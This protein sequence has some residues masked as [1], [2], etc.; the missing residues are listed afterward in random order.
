VDG[1]LNDFFLSISNFYTE[2]DDDL[3]DYN[4]ERLSKFKGIGEINF[5]D[6]QKLV[7]VT[8][9]ITRDLTERSGKKAQYEIAKK[10]LKKYMR[11]DAGIFVF[12]DSSGNFRLSLVYGTPDTTRMVWSNFR[13]FTYFISQDEPH[14]TFD[15][16]IGQCD[17]SSLGTI[18][19]AFS[20]ERVTK[21]FY[22][23]YDRKF[24]NS[25]SLIQG[26]GSSD[27]EKER[28]RLFTQ[29]LF[30]RLMFIA[31]IEKKGWLKFGS[32]IDYLYALW[33][34]YKKSSNSNT[35]FYQERLKLLFFAGLNTPN[36]IRK[37]GSLNKIIGDVQ[38]L[39]GGL[40]EE[41][42]DDRDSNI[43]VLDECLGNIIEDL[44]KRFNFTVTENTPI[45]VEVAVDPEML[46]KVFEEL[47]TGRHETGS[48]YTPK[49]VVSF[50]CREAI[51]AYLG[52]FEK[53]V[54]NQDIS[55]VSVADARNLIS[56][57]K[58]ITV[59]DPACGSGAYLVG[60]L[61]ELQTLHRILDTRA[62]EMTARDDYQL[63]LEI[64][65]NNLYG[66]DLDSFAVNIARLRLW[67]TLAVEYDGNKPEPLPNLDFKIEIGD[68]LTAPDP[69]QGSQQ[70]IVGE[71]AKR[72]DEKTNVFMRTHNYGLKAPLKKEIEEIEQ[73]IA[74]WMHA[75]AA[76]SG[77]DWAV[78]FAGVFV[79]GGFD[80]ILANPPYGI[81]C[82]DPL[83]F[84]YFPRVK[85]ED[86]QSKDSYGLFIARGLQMLKSGGILTYIVSDTWRTIRTHYPLRKKLINETQLMHVLDLP[87]WIFDATVN[88][89][90]FTTVKQ[91]PAE[92][93]VLIAGDLRN[94]PRGDWTALEQNLVTISA[95]GPDCS[96]STYARYTYPQNLIPTYD[97]LS[98]FIGSPNLYRLMSAKRFVRLNT[99]ADVK[100]G[101]ATADNQYY[102]R[103]R[104]DSRGSY[105]ILDQSHLMSEKDLANLSDSEK[106]NGVNPA[107][108]RNRHFVPYDKGGPSDADGG[109][110]PNY[111]VPTDYF[112]DWSQTA[113]TRLK[114]KT[115]E[116]QGGRLASR[117]QNF[118][119]YFKEGISFSDTGF[120][121]PT[122]RV[123]CCGV[124]DVMGM[125]VFTDE[126]NTKY[127]L[128][129]LASRLIRYVI[130]NY[131]NHSI[132]TQVEGL[133]PIPILIDNSAFQSRMIR[134]VDEIIT[135]QREDARYPY[136]LYEQ[137]EIDALVYQLYGLTDE[138]I[139]EVELWYCRRYPKLAEAQG[140]F[141]EVK[142]KYSEHL[143]RCDLVMTKGP[144]YWKS[145]PVLS[146]I[147][148][149]E[150]ETLEFKET[151]DAD[152]K[153][154][155]KNAGVLLSSLKTIAAFLNTDGGTMMIGVSDSG[156]I[157][158]L[159]KDYKL[160]NKHDKD[161][162]EQK[163][164]SLVT[165]RF[166]PEPKGK[167]NVSF[168][169]VEDRQ[170]CV[171]IVETSED[172][173]HLDGKD[174][175]IRE[176]NTSRKL[177]G[178]ALVNFVQNRSKKEQL[179]AYEL[180]DLT[181]EE[182]A[183]VEGNA[184]KA[185]K[186]NIT[187]AAEISPIEGVEPDDQEENIEEAA[188]VEIILMKDKETPGTWRYKEQ[189][190]DH[191]LTIYLTKEQVKEL[192][193]P[194]S[195]KITVT[196]A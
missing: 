84:Q 111:Y 8:A 3:V 47:V 33:N 5:E 146:L 124:F 172:I 102:L 175:Y 154:G 53:L 43:K 7:V 97:N 4:D 119:C 99:I 140:V 57:L 49:T 72:V 46:G 69:H 168:E 26:F 181:P 56:K 165:S 171:A 143:K 161:G 173:S 103:K 186:V 20:V 104:P 151:L 147:A 6:G 136:H 12:S 65:Q 17:F 38:Y 88:T 25:E 98:F 48:Y 21:E 137:K 73:H 157:I 71:L 64:I 107:K 29:T 126:I 23:E 190:E 89:C 105:Q 40:F 63:K 108:Y 195:I 28:K 79:S 61:H 129:I 14:R 127:L 22:K 54:D 159:E 36:G 183:V 158:G 83:R 90:I 1:N 134:L 142:E 51:K 125:S 112:I 87:S 116:K 39:N 85:G 44:F 121:A 32:Q 77:F 164:H 80:I 68:S 170:V 162:L 174:V 10:I 74:A 194:E 122:F 34:D 106:V 163:I 196:A 113:V 81:S 135:K 149:G 70:G 178:P 18:K 187:T 118:D 188:Q 145:N 160:C 45:D 109:W 100:Q 117:F 184:N 133:K 66:V 76:V 11:Y 156:E 94:L 96:T 91:T 185:N 67:L 130:K 92:S 19:E 55:N 131:I 30:N 35:S 50:M 42:E 169:Q 115:S 110:L 93:H 114:T 191:P 177:E 59:C 120:Y 182:I 152:S 153:T 82:E 150:G 62:A 155:D 148:Q 101:L 41:N 24:K 95:R 78:K 139:R 58:S 86:P 123:G 166:V 27:K 132:H 179:M 15:E 128:S 189:K 192:G 138:D 176:G 31:F 52:G 9:N 16:R 180:Y 167:V 193:N 37:N 13:R 141:S 144:D 75:G 60:I 2:K